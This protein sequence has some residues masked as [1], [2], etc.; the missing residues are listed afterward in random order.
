[1]LTEETVQSISPSPKNFTDGKALQKDLFET[2]KKENLFWGKCQGSAAK[3]YTV[4]FNANTLSYKCSCPVGNRG[5]VCKHT[6]GLMIKSINQPDVFAESEPPEW[7]EAWVKKQLEKKEKAEQAVTA[8]TDE[9]VKTGLERIR[10]AKSKTTK[11]REKQMSEGIDLLNSYLNDILNEGKLIAD[12]W[13]SERKDVLI[14]SLNSAKMPALAYMIEENL[15]N[16][17]A[18]TIAKAAV[19]SNLWQKR[20]T[21]SPEVQEFLLGALGSYIKKEEVI[22][23]K[24]IVKDT[25]LCVAYYNEY[26]YKP[27]RMTLHHWFLVGKTTGQWTRVMHT[28]VY[29]A[30]GSNEP[31]PNIQIGK[32]YQGSIA[33]FPASQRGILLHD[34]QS[35]TNE[36]NYFIP[37]QDIVPHY[38][39]KLITDLP[40]FFNIKSAK[41]AFIQKTEKENYRIQIQ[42]KVYECTQDLQALWIAQSEKGV[43]LVYAQRYPHKIIVLGGILENGLFVS[44]PTDLERAMDNQYVIPE[45]LKKRLEVGKKM[46]DIQLE[47]LDNKGLQPV[48]QWARTF[49]WYNYGVEKNYSFEKPAFITEKTTNPAPDVFF[50]AWLKGIKKYTFFVEKGLSMLA[51]KEL[52]L[53]PFML[54]HTAERLEPEHIEKYKK[55]LGNRAKYLFDTEVKTYNEQHYIQLFEDG[56]T[57]ERKEAYQYLLKNN[58]KVLKELIKKVYKQDKA[59]LRKYW[60]SS[61]N[62]VVLFDGNDETWILEQ[63]KNEKNNEIKQEW[64]WKLGNVYEGT[65]YKPFQTG[66]EWQQSLE[67]YI[68]FEKAKKGLKAKITLPEEKD[69]EYFTEMSTWKGIHG[70]KAGVLMFLLSC[71]PVHTWEYSTEELAKAIKGNE[72]EEVFWDGIVLACYRYGKDTPVKYIDETYQKGKYSDYWKHLFVPLLSTELCIEEGFRQKNF[73]ATFADAL[74]KRKDITQKHL[75]S[76]VEAIQSNEYK[77]YRLEGY[78]HTPVQIFVKHINYETLN[79]VTEKLSKCDKNIEIVTPMLESLK[80]LQEMYHAIKGI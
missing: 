62:D 11:N 46:G 34:W 21:L 76:I 49:L 35:S 1:M 52:A 50:K 37:E 18:E 22:Q 65:E 64:V 53:T 20:D 75:L 66:K 41:E 28:E 71:K 30:Y 2:G 26:R 72:Y 59:E 31:K 9:K 61:E 44:V 12:T 39:D 63:L 25:W 23:L 3:P 4:M 10:D 47:G 70:D 38:S 24:D 57:E 7:A 17:P 19:L 77:N 68:T 27:S 74:L 73:N 29:A 58:P 51:E 42:N 55:V 36:Q 8:Q 54:S 16:N 14:E 69:F 56:K 13:S 48:Q 78:A 15:E 60:I 67:K 45:L 5:I 6:L 80:I 32:T 33:Y 79:T 40:L 43:T